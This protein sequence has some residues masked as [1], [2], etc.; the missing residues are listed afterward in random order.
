MA[1]VFPGRLWSWL[2][3]TELVMGLLWLGLA[4]FT[5]ALVV[6]IWTRWGQ[7][8]PLR[9]C[10]VLSVLAH[11]LLAGYATTVRIV[12]MVPGASGPNIQIAY[13]EGPGGPGANGDDPAGKVETPRVAEKESLP[14]LDISSRRR[15][16]LT[17]SPPAENAATDPPS[18][19]VA[20]AVLDKPILP[21]EPDA[22]PGDPPKSAGLPE[23]P[24][25]SDPNA[26]DRVTV[27]QAMTAT[28]ATTATTTTAWPASDGIG[29]AGNLAPAVSQPGGEFD[30][31]A[32]GGLSASD[33]P[34]PCRIGS[35]PRRQPGDRG[36]RAGRTPMADGKPK[37][38]RTLERPT[39]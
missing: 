6:L 22:G 1:A 4:A 20:T 29:A 25:A 16:R 14:L 18:P 7:Y 37:S 24:V 30:P 15:H 27:S 12:A 17:S 23:E 39:T 13:V 35:R 26:T 8:R 36:S 33:G 11:L 2:T 38:R 31:R 3:G 21:S 10:L 28:T 9:K 32:A 5:V 19:P 34:E